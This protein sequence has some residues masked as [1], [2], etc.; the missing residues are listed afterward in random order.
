MLFLSTFS[1]CSYAKSA[2][3]ELLSV[4]VVDA[5]VEKRL[6]FG[7]LVLNE[8]VREVA[9]V[10]TNLSTRT[11]RKDLMNTLWKKKESLEEGKNS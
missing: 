2:H 1:S 8:A 9:I 11:R 6:R 7:L 5:E 4:A 10:R 3:L